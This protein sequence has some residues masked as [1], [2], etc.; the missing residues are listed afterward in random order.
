MAEQA[1]EIRY[2]A[3]P[4]AVRFHA[5]DAFVRGLRGPI[6]SGK[7]VT[8]VAE[9]LGRAIRQA[10]DA[11]GVRMSRWAVVRNTYP[12]LK[13]TTIKTFQRW[14][15]DTVCPLRWGAPIDGILRVPLADGTKVEAEFLFVALDRAEHVKKLLSMELTGAWLN[16]A[17]EINLAIVDGVTSRVGRYPDRGSAP[18]TWSGV[19]MD[20][21]PPDDDHWWYRIF[22]QQDFSDPVLIEMREQGWAWEQFVQPPALLRV[23]GEDG[24][25]RW[26]AN[27]L[28]ENVQ[29]QQLGYD[30]WRRM[31]FGKSQQWIQV[32]IAG[33]YGTVQDGKAVFPEWSEATHLRARDFVP[34]A[35]SKIILGW[36][37]GLTP[38]CVFMMLTERGVL[39]VFDEMT[40]SRMGIQ[41]FT[42]QVNLHL[43]T[44][45]PS[46]VVDREYGDPAGA[47]G[48]QTDER[49]CYDI[50]RNLGRAP[51]PGASNL[52]ERLEGVRW[53]LTR[54]V[55]GEPGFRLS[56]RCR[57]LRK[58]FN[59]GYR[60]RRLA[61][62]Y[63]DRYQEKPDKNEY[64]HVAD[65]LNHAAGVMAR[66]GRAGPSALQERE[67]WR[68]RGKRQARG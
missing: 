46:V 38:A 52:T 24:R 17:R 29:H 21:N 59:G 4:T 35:G 22:E 42:E 57:M 30:Y 65:A 50:Q 43:A 54:L 61:V 20:T 26:E 58:G 10:P 60:Y 66:A 64:S 53:F 34:A 33:Q 55:D 19:I 18:L 49:S 32:Y 40:S 3:E 23:E 11:S 2:D 68:G 7:S 39:E 16:E 47:A 14:V 31:L 63:D 6:G 62:N 28:A 51:Q 44:R 41:A 27:P 37:Y 1:L 5:S 48:A 15:P 8:C 13:T 56:P 36:D 12:E 9:L 25:V 67:A 45:Y